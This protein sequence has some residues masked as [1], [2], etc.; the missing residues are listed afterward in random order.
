MNYEKTILRATEYSGS[1]QAKEKKLSATTLAGSTDLQL[2]YNWLYS[3]DELLK[4][5]LIEH[6]TLGSVLQLGL[7]S[8]FK[9]NKNYIVA[10]R[11]EQKVGDW[12][13]SGEMDI[14][15]LKNKLIIDNKLT[16]KTSISKIK[17]EGKS[18]QY[19]IQLAIYRW[20]YYK[21]TNEKFDVALALFNKSA[22]YFKKEFEPVFEMYYPKIMDID[23]VEKYI[24]DKIETLE[25]Y[26]NN[27]IEPS[28]CE[29]LWWYV[30]SGK[31]IP[32]RCVYYCSYKNKC[33]YY[34]SSKELEYM[35]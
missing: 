31:K 32:M 20:L 17:K 28:K 24:K 11:I 16:N 34:N 33:S 19:A 15:D 9:D 14:I 35:I 2:Y 22:S 25:N 13:I 18:H 27:G 7:D 1:K 26:I 3:S 10:K 8:I 5:E 12:I 23:E 6:N 29:D 4:Q 30:K 21:E